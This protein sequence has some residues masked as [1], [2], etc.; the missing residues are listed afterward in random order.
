MQEVG[1]PMYLFFVLSLDLVT[2][3]QMPSRPMKFLSASASVR[4]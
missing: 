4:E 1:L 2:V 3:G